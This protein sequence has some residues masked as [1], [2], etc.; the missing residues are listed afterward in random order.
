MRDEQF[1]C[2]KPDAETEAFITRCKSI[3]RSEVGSQQYLDDDPHL[4]LYVGDF[5][6]GDAFLQTMAPLLPPEPV[7]V[8]LAGWSTF[9]DDPV[10]GGHTLVLSVEESGMQ[11]LRALQQSVVDAASPYRNP[12]VLDR[13]QDPS[14]FDS[15]M[16]A[17]LER[18]GFPFVGRIWKAHLTIASFEPA[19]YEN[20]A[21][22]LLKLQPPQ[23]VRFPVLALMR[24]TSSGFETR[25]HWRLGDA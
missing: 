8:P 17:S 11:P 10:T 20:V 15:D 23:T 5:S 9:R 24:I 22:S 4:T 1:F 18:Y 7:E 25:Q 6:F 2:L 19:A 14:G 21:A 16:M 13:Y 3:A 12:G